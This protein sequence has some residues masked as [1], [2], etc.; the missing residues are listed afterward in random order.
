MHLAFLKNATESEMR[1]YVDGVEKVNRHRRGSTDD[2]KKMDAPTAIGI[3]RLGHSL[4]PQKNGWSPSW[5]SKHGFEGQMAEVRIWNVLRTPEEILAGMRVSTA[6]LP[7]KDG[8]LLYGPVNGKLA[9]P[10]FA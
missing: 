9:K 1:I 10:A 2:R 6:E 4:P 8:L 7:S 5:M 3:F